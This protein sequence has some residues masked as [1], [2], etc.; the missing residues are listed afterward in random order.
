MSNKPTRAIPVQDL[1]E[2]LDFYVERLGLT[3]IERFA[4]G[5]HLETAFGHILLAGP[6][7]GDPEPYM[8][9]TYEVV[10][11]GGNL[12]GQCELSPAGD[13]RP[14]GAVIYLFTPDIEATAR[15]TGAPLIRTDWG[16]RRVELP[17]PNGYTISYWTENDLTPEEMLALF[18]SAPDRLDAALAGLTEAQLDLVR[19]PGKWAIRQIVHHITDSAIGSIARLRFGVA[20]PGRLYQPNV[21]SPDVWDRALASDRRPVGPSVALFRAVHEHMMQLVEFVPG[22]LDGFTVSESGAKSTVSRSLGMLA[23]HAAGHIDQIWQTR[24]NH[25]L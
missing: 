19:A 1:A 22:A 17:D 18:R 11:P 12:R 4:D 10:M 9:A 2:S 5:A 14:E 13:C 16:E 3:V 25:G 6:A 24:R 15:Q 23:A 8:A 7:L 21:Y 20:E